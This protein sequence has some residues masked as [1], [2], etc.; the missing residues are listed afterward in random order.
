[1]DSNAIA[2][3]NTL[4]KTAE[5]GMDELALLLQ[6]HT[7]TRG[8]ARCSTVLAKYSECME[9]YA[10]GGNRTGAEVFSSHPPRCAHVRNRTRTRVVHVRQ[11]KV[12]RRNKKRYTRGLSPAF[13]LLLAER[14]RAASLGK[15]FFSYPS[16]LF[17]LFF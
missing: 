9:M 13:S 11:R 15:P 3:R 17:F 12:R 16:P 2:F 4:R 6:R 1:M 10:F 7:R 8:A 5:E 14:L